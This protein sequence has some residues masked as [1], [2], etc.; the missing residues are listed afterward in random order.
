L[1]K[2]YR[3]LKRNGAVNTFL[4]AGTTSSWAVKLC[5]KT[6]TASRPAATAVEESGCVEIL[7][8]DFEALLEHFSTPWKIPSQISVNDIAEIHRTKQLIT[9]Y[10]E[11]HKYLNLIPRIYG[12][13]F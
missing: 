8:R 2:S 3:G 7:A 4:T 13:F 5:F 12:N 10:I 6:H 9:R 11:Q 1:I